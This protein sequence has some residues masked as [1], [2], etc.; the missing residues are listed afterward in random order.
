MSHLLN[1]HKRHRKFENE[2]AVS[3]VLQSC[4]SD[5]SPAILETQ[6]ENGIRTVKE[7]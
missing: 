7:I 4:L 6:T 1:K 3:F 5:M 2:F